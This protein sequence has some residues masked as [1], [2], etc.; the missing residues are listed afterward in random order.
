MARKGGTLEHLSEVWRFREF[1]T[2]LV[3][4]N[5]KV[6]YQRSVLGFIWTLLNPL[7]TVAVI[8]AIFS[9]VVRIEMPQ[10][11]AFL[12][13]GYFVWNYVMQ[14]LSSATYVLGEHAQLSRSVAFPKVIP[15]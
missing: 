10:Y 15:V 13:S 11:W 4:R 14:T 2:S 8:A 3:V 9:Y 5:L 6:K 12:L 7:L 1:L